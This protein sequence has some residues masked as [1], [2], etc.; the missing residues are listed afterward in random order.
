[1]PPTSFEKLA[2]GHQFPPA[3]YE[4]TQSVIAKYVAAVGEKQAFLEEDTVPPLGMAAYA[5]NAL[6]GQFSIPPGSIHASQDFHFIKRVPIG[7]TISCIGK[8][9]Q[10]VER[11]R[12]TLVVLEIDAVNQANNEKVLTGKSTIAIPK[13]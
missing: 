6:S 3:S 11:G 12:L 1:M 9:A 4:L 10:K 8:I 7:T 2:V 5:I 13:I